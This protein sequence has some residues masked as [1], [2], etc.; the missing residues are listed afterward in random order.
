MLVESNMFNI[1]LYNII[2]HNLS[3]LLLM[4]KVIQS[5]GDTSP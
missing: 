2:N 1:A 5:L 3:L 4:M